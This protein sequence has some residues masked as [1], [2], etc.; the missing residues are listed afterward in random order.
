MEIRVLRYFLET[1]REGNMTRAAERLHVTQPTLSRQIR[2]LEAELGKPLF[3]RHNTSVSL[4][5]EGMIL[6]KR[7]EDLISIADKIENEFQAMDEISG[8]RIQIGCAESYLIRYLAEAVRRV[9]LRYPGITFSILSGGTEQMDEKLFSGVLD[10]AFIVEPP[11]LSRFNYLEIPKTDTWGAYMLCD[12]PLAEKEFL[13]IEDLKPYPLFCS[14]QSVRA[15]LTRWAGDAA[16]SLNILANFNLTNNSLVFARAGLGLALSFDK[17]VELT[18]ES[19]LVFRPLSPV[20]ENKMYVIW[21]KYQVFSP[22]ASF[23]LE[24]IK[25]VIA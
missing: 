2:D 18:S 8:G 7:A 5:E 22:A 17:I 12:C 10:M 14:E 24:E 13:T 6:R 23:L 4:T 20:L 9:H 21:N 11:D 15:D 1:A 25:Q 19:S 3:V 16:E